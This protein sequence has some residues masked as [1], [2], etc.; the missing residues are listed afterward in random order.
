VPV[1]AFARGGAKE[2]VIHGETGFLFEEPN[3]QGFGTALD[4]FKDMNFNK[5]TI[6][7]NAVK[8]S[9]NSFKKKISSYFQQ[10]WA[11]HESQL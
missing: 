11:E 1:I 4:K 9:R 8:F 2:T 5:T 7:A 10:K 3:S 6:R